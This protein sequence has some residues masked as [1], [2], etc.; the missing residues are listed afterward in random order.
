MF[1]Y[2]TIS[3]MGLLSSHHNIN[4][5][6]AVVIVVLFCFCNT[7]SAEDFKVSAV[8]APLRVILVDKDHTIIRILSNSPKE[9]IPTVYVNTAVNRISYNSRIG[10]QYIQL[11]KTIDYSKTGIVYQRGKSTKKQPIGLLE[12]MLRYSTRVQFLKFL[13]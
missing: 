3:I 2:P 13:I 12:T 9:V 8:V 5:F 4:M 7:V 1:I 6:S 11:S 10:G